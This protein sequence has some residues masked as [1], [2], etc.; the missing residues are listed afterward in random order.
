MSAARP[1]LPNPR[2]SLMPQAMASTFFSA[3]PISTPAPAKAHNNFGRRLQLM[4]NR[5][6]DPP[7]P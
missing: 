3:P 5:L 2:P 4:G 6:F 7:L 1:L